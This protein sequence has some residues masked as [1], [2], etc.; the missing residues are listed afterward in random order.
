VHECSQKQGRREQAHGRNAGLPDPGEEKGVTWGPVEGLMGQGPPEDGVRQVD[1]LPLIE[2]RY[3][4]QGRP[5]V[6]VQV[7]ERIEDR[8]DRGKAHDN[9]RPVGAGRRGIG[10]DRLAS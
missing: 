2:N 1:V 7:Q 9:G 5:E 4:A 6:P 8:G 3:P 10:L